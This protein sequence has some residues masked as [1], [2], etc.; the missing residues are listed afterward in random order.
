MRFRDTFGFGADD[1][2]SRTHIG[3]AVGGGFEHAFSHHLSLKVEYQYIN[4]GSEHYVMLETVGAVRTQFADHTDT[5]TDFH[6]V[7]LGL[8]YKFGEHREAVPLK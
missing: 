6:T 3:Y 7:R 2:A 1:S 4:F 8:N 5:Q